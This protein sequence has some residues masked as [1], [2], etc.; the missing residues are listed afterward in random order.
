MDEGDD[1]AVTLTPV[2]AGEEV[3]GGKNRQV[4]TF[5]VTLAARHVP[6]SARLKIKN[7]WL[8][9]ARAADFDAARTTA[10]AVYLYVKAVTRESADAVETVLL[11]ELSGG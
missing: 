7:G 4:R 5:K 9:D 6:G 3:V 10:A 2:N 11:C 8:E 1:V